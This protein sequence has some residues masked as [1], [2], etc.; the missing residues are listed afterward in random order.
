MSD[1]HPVGPELAAKNRRTLA[2]RLGWPAG[3]VE[4]CERIE[5]ESPGWSVSWSDGGGLTWEKP[6]FY[7]GVINWHH[8][9]PGPRFVYG[10]TA[11][12][13]RSELADRP[14]PKSGLS[15]YRPL[16]RPAGD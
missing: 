4:E 6:G 14:V 7:A 5:A 15:E 11:D 2:E 8:Y 13:L 9:D 3:T 16:E 10:A 12:E 1:L